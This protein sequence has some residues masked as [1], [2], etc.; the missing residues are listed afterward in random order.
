L[1][2]ASLCFDWTERELEEGGRGFKALALNRMFPGGGRSGL[3]WT[4]CFAP[5]LSGGHHEG[6]FGDFHL[7]PCL[8]FFFLNTIHML[9]NIRE[10]R[11]I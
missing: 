5:P 11:N 8:E 1:G 9:H 4:P 2:L 6:Q 7:P 3:R 10:K